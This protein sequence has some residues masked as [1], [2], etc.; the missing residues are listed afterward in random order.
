MKWV[1]HRGFWRNAQEANSLAALEEAFAR[2]W[3]IETD[4]RQSKGALFLSHDP[5]VDTRS[6]ASWESFTALWD[7]YPHCP[8]FLNIK[9]DGLLKNLLPYLEQWSKRT[10]VCFDMSVPELVRYSKLIPS[11]QLATRISEFESGPLADK[12]DWVWCDHFGSDLRL[13]EL[14]AQFATTQ[15]KKLVLVSPELHGRDPSGFLSD[16]EAFEKHR[17][18]PVYLC[19]DLLP[20]RELA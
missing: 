12:C 17:G 4:L 14:D 8:V 11:S 10:V 9:E 3:G 7:H 6:S 16:A 5:L 1:G 15:G 20:E 13:H 19:T 2:G 18:E